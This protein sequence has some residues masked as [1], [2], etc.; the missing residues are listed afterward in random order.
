MKKILIWF[1]IFIFG[2]FSFLNIS[3]ASCEFNG[4]IKWNFNSCFE[5]S[6]LVKADD[7]KLDWNWFKNKIVRFTEIISVLI[8]IAAVFWIVF[9]AFRL[10]ISSW[11]EEWINNA[12]KNFLWTILWFTALLFASSIVVIVIKFFYSL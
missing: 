1:C 3:F 9:S 7:L 2:I 4:E 11:K 5:E 6:K 10:V 8:W 12:K